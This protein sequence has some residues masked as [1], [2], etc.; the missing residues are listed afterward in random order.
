MKRIKFLRTIIVLF[1]LIFVIFAGGCGNK[2][3]S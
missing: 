2:V 3:N 1:T